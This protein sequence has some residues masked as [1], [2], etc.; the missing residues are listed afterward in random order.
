[1]RVRQVY[2]I[3]IYFSAVVAV[4]KSGIAD[5]SKRARLAYIVSPIPLALESALMMAASM[6]AASQS[7]GWEV[8]QRMRLGL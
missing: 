8:R 5:V 6:M 7:R 4:R 2:A 3:V 1:M